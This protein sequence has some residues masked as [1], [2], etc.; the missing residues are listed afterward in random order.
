MRF[1][2]FWNALLRAGIHGPEVDKWLHHEKMTFQYM[3]DM[4]TPP[5]PRVGG[6][7]VYHPIGRS[8]S[9]VIDPTFMIGA[10]P[11]GA[12]D[13][14]HGR[15]M[16]WYWEQQ[17]KPSPDCMGTTGGRDL[18]LT[19]L[20]FSKLPAE[21]SAVPPLRSRRWEGMGAIFRSQVGSEYESNIVFRHDPF[22]WN[23]YE[24]N[25]GALY[26]YGKGAPLLPRFGGYWMGQ[27]G[28]PTLMSVPFGNRVLFADGMHDQDWTNG[29]G[30]MQTFASL[31]VLADYADGRTLDGAW[32]RGTLF[33]KDLNRD[34]PV[35]LLVRDDVTRANVASALHWWV[36]SKAVQ[37]EGIE[38]PG[39]VLLKGTDETW[40]ANMG[41]NWR[42]APVLAG[43][44]QYFTGQCGVDLDLFIA[45][46]SAPNI[47]TDA[48]GVSAHAPYNNNPRMYEFQQL[49]RIEQPAGKTSYLTLLAP[50]WPGSPVP[51]YRTI[52]EGTGVAVTRK[53]GEDRLFLCQHPVTY[54][55]KLVRFAGQAGFARI[56][57]AA[58]LRLMV[59]DG[60]ISAGGIT[61]ATASSAA[62]VYDG[63][64]ITVYC[65]KD[66]RN[67][68][69]K[70]S[71][72]MNRVK[73]TMVQE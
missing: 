27:K 54:T 37:P 68:T 32:W 4:L 16:R 71:G 24:A 34:D 11:F 44:L 36:L 31:G 2:P 39:V 20:A 72:K 65:P 35:Y 48:A 29:L 57:G 6:R 61:L 50:R 47:I 12:G 5:E 33:A 22:A 60:S 46:P 19:L 18:S 58:P 63:K 1:G 66:A 49:V 38:Q 13:P 14:D 17:G 8:S 52:A 56:G 15:M 64:T 53:D 45:T 51:V 9:G 40:L 28:Q 41:K 25:N 26:F 69:V 59:L 73:V 21:S 3:G 10:D 70:R 62:L 55:D 43:Q 23:L 7:R 30:T 67:V 42:D